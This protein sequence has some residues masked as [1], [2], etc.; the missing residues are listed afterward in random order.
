[1]SFKVVVWNMDSWRRKGNAKGWQELKKLQPD[2]ALLNEATR[3]EVRTGLK[4]RGR[5]T[6][7]GRDYV[8]P[9]ASLIA[10][11]HKMELVDA[12]VKKVPFQISRPGAW[13]AWVVSMPTSNGRQE[14]VTAVSVYGLLDEMSDASVHRSLSELSPIFDDRR[15]NKL[16]LLGGDLN[17]WTGWDPVKEVRH[18]ARDRAVLGRI[19][20][21]GLRDCLKATRRAGRLKGCPCDSRA[22]CTHSRT[23]WDH[24]RIPYQMDYLFASPALVERLDGAE[25]TCNVLDTDE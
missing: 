22:E 13:T 2:I 21:Y 4:V 17:T 23:R 10:S 24:R 9:W 25:F 16:I 19:E 15:Y 3:P 20:A 1:M 6:T 11:P 7:R 5:T 14:N 8:R 12:R 18:L